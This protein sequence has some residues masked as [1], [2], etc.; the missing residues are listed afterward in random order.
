MQTASSEAVSVSMRN[1]RVTNAIL[2]RCRST[3]SS[4]ASPPPAIA[5]L[6]SAGNH[7]VGFL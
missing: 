3:Q 1:L 7:G 6:R 4:A 2:F 5:S